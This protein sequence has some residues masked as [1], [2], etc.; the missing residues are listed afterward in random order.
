MDLEYVS[1]RIMSAGLKI[2]PKTYNLFANFVDDMGHVLLEIGVSTDPKKIEA[3][4]T[5]IEHTLVK[6]LLSFWGL[7]S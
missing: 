4:N 1:K 3:I 5:W 6:E 7:W 2:K